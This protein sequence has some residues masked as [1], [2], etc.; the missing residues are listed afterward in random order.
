MTVGKWPNTIAGSSCSLLRY[1][2]ITAKHT[3]DNQNT[4]LASG[5]ALNE[6][7]DAQSTTAPEKSCHLHRNATVQ[8]NRSRSDERKNRII[9]IRV[10]AGLMAAVVV[11][12]ADAQARLKP[13]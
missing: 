3:Q 7:L 5:A 11:S 6:N 2:R 9:T 4:A 10:M 8:I 12:Q 13:S 1:D